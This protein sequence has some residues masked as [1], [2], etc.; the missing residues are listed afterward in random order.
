M[1]IE[2]L[3]TLLKLLEH[4]INNSFYNKNF[5]I[6]WSNYWTVKTTIKDEE[7]NWTN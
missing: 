4:S 3:N 7:K 6:K 1:K 2:T 5:K